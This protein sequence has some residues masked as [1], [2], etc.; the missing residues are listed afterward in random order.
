MA[1]AASSCVYWFIEACAPGGREFLAASAIRMRMI[2][3]Q[4]IDCAQPERDTANVCS[5]LASAPLP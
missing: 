4:P 5:S 3:R 2:A 1:A